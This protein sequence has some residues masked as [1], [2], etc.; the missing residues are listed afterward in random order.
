MDV[1]EPFGLTSAMAQNVTF[2]AP[3]AS[4]VFMIY[5]IAYQ[6]M[7]SLIATI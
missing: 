6:H 4:S 7:P 2:R 5:D 1:D 3:S